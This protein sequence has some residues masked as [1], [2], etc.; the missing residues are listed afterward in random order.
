MK[1]GTYISSKPKLVFKIRKLEMMLRIY[2]V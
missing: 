2:E 1:K